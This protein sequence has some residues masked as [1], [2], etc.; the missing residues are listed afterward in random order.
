M[1]QVGVVDLDGPPHRRTDD[2]C[3]GRGHGAVLSDGCR[4]PV[5]VGGQTGLMSTSVERVLAA[6]IDAVHDEEAYSPAYDAAGDIT[7]SAPARAIL[8]QFVILPKHAHDGAPSTDRDQLAALIPAPR[9]PDHVRDWP[10]DEIAF[11]RH[12]TWTDFTDRADQLDTIRRYKVADTILD[13][14]YTRQPGT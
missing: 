14:G 7:T 13:A 1:G 6:L 5:R 4:C 3:S 8:D 11:F 12:G 2:L 9:P 10:L